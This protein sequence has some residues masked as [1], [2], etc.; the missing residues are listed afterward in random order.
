[1]EDLV[2]PDST[3]LVFGDSGITASTGES[4]QFVHDAQGRITSIIAPDGTQV[5]YTYDSAGNLVAA[6][7]LVAGQSS[8]YGYQTGPVHLL[9]EAVAPASGTS[10]VIQY[11][12]SFQVLP[13]TADLGSSGQFLASNRSGMLAAGGTD[14]YAF[15]LRPSELLATASGTVYLGISVQAAAGSVLQPAVPALAGLTTL[16]THTSTTSAFALYDITQAGLERLDLSGANSSTSGGYTLHIFVAGDVNGDETVDGVDAQLLAGAMGTSVGQPGYLPAADA[17]QDGVINATDAQL[18]GADLGFQANLPPTVTAGQGLTHQDL[19]VSVDLSPLASDPAGNPIY[20]RVLNPQ[21]GTATL[22]ADG[23][24]AI[25]LPAPGY[26]GPASFQ[27]QADDGYGTSAPATVSVN[28]SAAPLVNLDFVTR[29][30]VLAPGATLVE[31]VIG[32]FAD[33]K[34]IALPASYVSFQ[35]TD[36]T[37]AVVSPAGSVSAQTNGTAVLLAFSHGIQAATA[38]RVGTPT[39][40][41]SQL[42]AQVGLTADPQAVSL[43]AG[44]GTR[45]LDISLDHEIDLTAASTGT[46]YYISNPAVV[47]VSPDGMITAGAPGFATV[48]AINGPAEKVI[49]VKVE[50]PEVGPAVLGPG[51]GVVQGSDG[52]LV[53]VGPG[54]LAGNATVNIAPVAQSNLPMA[55]PGGLITVGAFHLDLGPDRLSVPVQLSVAVAPGTPPGTTVFFY[56]ADTVPD[57]SG[58]P[59]PVW[60][61][62]AKGV[63]GPNGFT[64]PGFDLTGTFICGYGSSPTGTVRG[65]IEV[66]D[67]L[68]DN[69]NGFAVLSSLGGGSAV[70]EAFSLTAGFTFDLNLGTNPAELEE[71]PPPAPPRSRRSPSRS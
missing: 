17:N 40:L 27:Y 70:G 12:P 19:V 39:D 43:A 48:T 56:R 51:G 18:L 32:D 30:I 61:E 6:R 47:G 13:L 28:V 49:P 66:A 22:A 50:P 35:T 2:R 11:A 64:D 63:V 5:I 10:A 53:M 44:V 41:T 57:A 3:S 38:I 58:N 26:T 14:R 62:V 54:A 25:F 68:N 42:L 16:A 31:K 24:T 65:H 36:A 34:G 45:Q 9:T 67:G 4:I 33:E 7:N 69:G 55:P 60:M 46:V 1:V 8:R 52:S 20:F 21:N 29:P 15:S 37:V 23:H 59:V 71:I